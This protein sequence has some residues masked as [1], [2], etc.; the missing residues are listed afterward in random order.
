MDSHDKLN[1]PVWHSLNELQQKFALNYNKL[2]CYDPAFC[3]F[4]GWQKNGDTS[5]GLFDYASLV[6]AFYIVGEKPPLPPGI[7][8][9]KELICLQMIIEQP[10]D[11][12]QKG[13]IIKLNDQHHQELFELVNLVQPGYFRN[14]TM[15]LGDYFGV[16][17]NGQ[18]VAV[19]GER[20]KMH[21]FTEIS[22][23]VTH[24]DHIGKGYASQL[25][26]HTVTKIFD[27]AK[28]PFLHVADANTPAI[29][30]YKKLGFATRRKISFWNLQ[31]I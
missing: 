31:K 13:D 19:T 25:I 7:K 27:E 26:A 30:L 20:M 12:Q 3:A 10:I 21:G 14:K 17:K 6:N 2:K 24:P 9:K 22:A 1:N 5:I 16:F 29:A 15:S 11:L 4:G 8:Q 18:L 23:V 28:T